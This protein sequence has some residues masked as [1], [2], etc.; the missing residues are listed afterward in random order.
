MRS[1][2]LLMMLSL[3]ACGG[4]APSAPGHAPTMA[5]TD[6]PATTDPHAPP[7]ATLGTS[8]PGALLGEWGIALDH[9]D[10]AT[11]PGD[12]FYQHV[13]G[14]W[15][16]SFDIPEGFSSYGAFTQLFERAQRQ[17]R[18]LVDGT[19]AR[20]GVA[21]LPQKV[22]AYYD[23]FLDRTAINTKGL[24][25]IADQ[26][27]TYRQ[28]QTHAD[29][30][31]AMARI[32]FAA[33]APIGIYVDVD[34]MSPDQY[35]VYVTQS[36]LGMPTRDYYLDPSFSRQQDAYQTYL[37]TMLRLA[38]TPAPKDAARKVYALETQ[39][40][41]IH[42]RPEKRRQAALTYHRYTVEELEVYAPQLPWRAI[43][44]A[45]GVGT[46]AHFVVRENDAIQQTA[47]LFDA[48]PVQVWRD[49]L[50]VHA[51]GQSA[52]VLPETIE[53][54]HFAF[55]GRAL[56]G[57]RAPVP[58]W[59]AGIKAL[60]DAMGEAVGELYVNRYFP[61]ETKQQIDE[62]VGYV[63]TAFAAR[64][65]AADW[66]AAAT[67]AKAQEK[68]SALNTKIGYPD[69][70]RDFSSLTI[71][72]G[73][74]FGNQRRVRQFQHQT[75]LAKLNGPVDRNEWSMLPQQVNAY[76]SRSRNEIVFPAA[77]LQAPF[78]DPQADPAVN[79]GAIGATIGHE[80]GHGFDDQG[81]QADA[82]GML[83]DWWRRTDAEEFEAR[84]MALGAQYG[85]YEPIKGVFINADRT[86]GENIGDLVGLT[87]AYDAYQLFLDGKT[88]PV[89]DGLTGDQRFFMA[90][91]QVWQRKYR[92]E[93]LRRRLAVD[94]HA[95]AAYRTNGVVRNI[96]AWYDAFDV[97]EGDALYL[98]PEDRVRI[99]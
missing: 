37:A 80:I 84:A 23:S 96:D 63:K 11:R 76:Y 49:Y 90:W 83:S 3:S 67:K 99:W 87:T 18:D 54:A 6:A 38:G 14:A 48:T 58:R 32:D 60:N 34:A 21:P 43:F 77:L 70:F 53:A 94:H 93:E 56:S 28:M 73:D 36:G 65:E 20:E 55:Y 89:I 19:R 97:Q 44:A 15:Q 9:R 30:A 68:L 24:A 79:F 61:P 51:L 1:V 40:A 5:P 88:P 86:I 74:A 62:L 17:V 85:A 8:G 71:I 59:Q 35:A 98:S 25:P 22:G 45:F 27:A 4:D 31:G 41:Q 78:F 72:A 50:T 75:M 81:R 26:L 46:Q 82:R 7:G 2:F 10:L 33:R 91:A 57:K 42:W 12:D 66:M 47:A 29:V 13:N 92:P 16:E 52:P 64:L 39:L 69:P 95:P